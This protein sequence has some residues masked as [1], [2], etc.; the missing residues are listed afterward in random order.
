MAAKEVNEM[1][2]EN[3]PEVNLHGPRTPG[4]SLY[5]CPRNAIRRSPHIILKI[6][7]SLDSNISSQ[8][9]DPLLILQAPEAT[10]GLWEH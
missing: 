3:V 1:G 2:L 10:S 5:V 4:G 7:L 6:R 9:E 8:N